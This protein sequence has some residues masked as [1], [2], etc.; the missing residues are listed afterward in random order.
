MCAI[1]GCERHCVGHGLCRLHYDRMRAKG[2]TDDTRKN[3]RGVCS[4]DGCE[5]LHAAKGLCDNHWRQ[6][7]QKRQRDSAKLANPRVC[8]YC[9][10]PIEIDR[11]RVGSISYCSR[12]CKDADYVLTGR[13]AQAMLKSYYKR[14][15]G[16]TV[17]QVAEMRARGCAVCSTPDGGGRFNQLHIDHCHDLGSVRGVLCNNCNT[18]LGHFKDDPALLRAAADYVEAHRA[19]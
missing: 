8:A 17:D 1:D 15:Y 13:A 16:L 2:S 11:K 9:A 19:S 12:E 3:V 14:K 7:R 10:T 18:G 4:V 6:K 5:R